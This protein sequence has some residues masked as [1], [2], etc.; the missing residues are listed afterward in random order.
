VISANGVFN[1]Q[2]YSGAECGLAGDTCGFG[3][4]GDLRHFQPFFVMALFLA[5]LPLILVVGFG[6]CDGH[7]QLFQAFL[8]SPFT[9][10]AAAIAG[11]TL[12]LR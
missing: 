6:L 4:D 8:R 12:P 3:V 9:Y 11:T 5:V 10:L 7:F 2:R 1:F